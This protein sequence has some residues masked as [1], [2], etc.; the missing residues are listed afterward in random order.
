MEDLNKQQL[1]LLCV[2]ISF[3]T[4]IATGIITVSLLQ[5]VPLQV[6]QII[7]QVVERTIEKVIP[8]AKE[9]IKIQSE[10]PQKSSEELIATAIDK[11]LKSIV[12]LT[13]VN[14][15]KSSSFVALG[16]VT[17]SDGL[18]VVDKYS[19]FEDGNY[20]A[21][22]SDGSKYSL[23]FENSNSDFRLFR[24]EKAGDDKTIFN[25]IGTESVDKIKLGQT[26]IGLGGS[27]RDAVSIGSVASL[28]KK[29]SQSNTETSTSTP[30][31]IEIGAIEAQISSND[32]V[33]GSPIVDISGNVLG[34]HLTKYENKNIFTPL[35]IP[36]V[37]PVAEQ[38]KKTSN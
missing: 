29:E 7:N 9:I 12:R 25:S 28:I 4:S 23:K 30:P 24:A 20:T 19:T 32:I 11:N 36:T 22:F 10:T 14:E 3:V 34:M 31:K 8:G 33:S 17:S 16:L 18:I 1:I 38:S 5:E 13:Q 35:N 26:L 15:D 27:N 6:P 37:K 21:V 2:M